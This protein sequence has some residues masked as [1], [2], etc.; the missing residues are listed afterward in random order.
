MPHKVHMMIAAYMYSDPAVN[1]AEGLGGGG[2]ALAGNF[3]QVHRAKQM[4]ARGELP[5]DRPGFV[6]AG[7]EMERINPRAQFAPVPKEDCLINEYNGGGGFGDPLERDP[8]L[9]RVDVEEECVSRAAV[10]RH[11]GVIFG[12]NGEVDE[13]ATQSCRDA[14]RAE[15][16]AG[17]KQWGAESRGEGGPVGGAVVAIEGAAGG[18][19]VISAE[20]ELLWACSSCGE[21]FGPAEGNFKL[22]AGYRDDDP[23]QVDERLYPDPAQFGDGTIVLRRYFCPSCATMLAQDFCRADDPPLHDYSIRKLPIGD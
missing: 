12:P 22:A 17:A 23:H 21:Q 9:V 7:F 10:E 13:R 5:G 8:E 4:M 20:G 18:V 2:Y 1:T 14:I 15:R 16:L 3:F 19:D 11:C 6:E